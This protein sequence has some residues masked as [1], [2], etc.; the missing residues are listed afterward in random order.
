[1]TDLLK[2]FDTLEDEF[3]P[4]SK[5]RRRE[6]REMRRQRIAEERKALKANE[7]WDAKPK[8]WTNPATQQDLEL[9]HIGAL[10]KAL[11]RRPVTIRSWIDKGW[12]PKSSFRTRGRLG[13]R[14]DAGLRLWTRAQIEGMRQIAEE[15]GLLDDNPPQ[16]HR[17]RFT[18]RVLAAW[19]G[20]T[21]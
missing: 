8:Q 1:M 15:E 2:G 19:K 21:A 17:T 13:T 14:G 4:G 12:I 5:Q 18:E 20:W 9:F 10:A 6:S 11:H 3:Y 16:I 7:G